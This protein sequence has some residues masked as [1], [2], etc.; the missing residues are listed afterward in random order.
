MLVRSENIFSHQRTPVEQQELRGVTVFIAA[1][2]FHNG[3]P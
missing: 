3:L 1:P 2:L